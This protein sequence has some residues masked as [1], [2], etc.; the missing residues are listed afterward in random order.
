MAGRT[1][2]VAFEMSPDV[3]ERK[4]VGVSNRRSLKLG[5]AMRPDEDDIDAFRRAA[6][7]SI[8]ACRPRCSDDVMLTNEHARANR[9]MSA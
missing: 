9:E 8:P 2:T 6:M 7:R 1:A 4:G 3:G 5:G